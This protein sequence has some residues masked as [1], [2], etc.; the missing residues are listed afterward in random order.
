MKQFLEYFLLLGFLPTLTSGQNSVGC[1]AACPPIGYENDSSHLCPGS[2]VEELAASRL[3]DIC[4]PTVLSNAKLSFS[5]FKQ[6][7]HVTVIANYYT[8]CEAGRRESG[9]FAGIAQRIHDETSGKVNFVTS[10]KGGGNCAQWAGIYQSDALTMGLNNGVKPSTQPLTVSD[11]QYDLRDSFFT[12]PYPHPS[13]IILDENLVVTYKSVGPCCG[14]VSY[15][16]CTD[17]VALGLDATLTKEIYAIYDKQ[18]NALIVEEETTTT[19]TTTTAVPDVVDTTTTTTTSAIISNIFDQPSNAACQSTTWS[20]W[21]QCS[22]TC[23]DGGIQFRYTLNSELPVETRPCPLILPECPEQCVPEFGLTFD[24]TVIVSSGLDSPRDL[25]FHPTPGL[26][27]GKRSEGRDFNPDEGEEL[28]VVN[29][30]SHDVTIVASVG[31]KFQQTISRRDRGYYHYMNNVTALSFNTVKGSG[32]N[33]DQDTVNYFAVCNDNLNDY[34]GYKESNNFM[35]PTLYDTD[36]TSPHKVGKKNTVNR[37]GEDCSGDS[38]DQCFFLHA[39]MLHESPACIGITHDPEVVTAYGAVYWAFDTTGDNSGN[40]GQ[41]VMFDFQQPHGP[42][43]MD[44]S[45]ASVR[46]YTEVKLYRDENLHAGMVVHQDKRRLFIVNPGKGSIVAVDIDTGRYA[47][48]AREEYPIFSNRLPSFEYSIYECVDQEEVFVNGLENPTGLA[49]SLDGSR[50]FVAARGGRIHAYEVETGALLQSIDLAS[51]GYSSIAGLA[52]SPESGSIYFV[53]MSTNQVVKVDTARF[54]EGQCTY[55]SVANTGFQAA[56]DAAKA[57]VESECAGTSL[58]LTRDYTCKVDGV[59]PNGTLFEQVHTDGYASDNPDVQSTAGMDDGAALLANRT[60]CEYDGDLNFD[61]LLLGGYYCHICLPRNDG[62]S[63]DEGG[64][65]LNVQWEGFTCDNEYFIDLDANKGTL[66]ASSNYFN[67]TYDN[68]LE[69][70]SG[71][72]YRF[73]VRTGDLNPVMISAIPDYLPVLTIVS[74]SIEPSE[75]VSKG[76]IL[77][78]TDS[79]TPEVLYLTSPGV[80]AIKLTIKGGAEA[81]VWDLLDPTTSTSSS[82]SLATTTATLV[83]SALALALFTF[84]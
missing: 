13:Y 56:L 58:S 53:D 40:G 27:L 60:D 72:T 67:K 17:D 78:K 4:H 31:T 16:D 24:A 74:R 7:G 65:C 61:A 43:S 30:N 57:Q 38:G 22:K 66:V 69:L 47:R 52:V 33:I 28:W 59:I 50:L 80:S 11:T 82:F 68:E 6:P 51:F 76:P 55:Q 35:G 63:C 14:Y 42:G 77:L 71:I 23:G 37:L 45:I 1:S 20:D 49:L 41:L 12:S 26:H 2:P 10:L 44:H 62:A 34:L 70:V 81:N 25:A 18:I 21:S 73:T 84:L 8:G 83:S 75:A 9:V 3:H 79:A 5:R 54:T 39:D 19:T 29:G 32:R 36:T 15:Y 64:S 48:T 46:R